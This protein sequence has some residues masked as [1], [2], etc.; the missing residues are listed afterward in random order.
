MGGCIM[1]R[2][3]P[4]AS[5]GETHGQSG[6]RWLDSVAPLREEG[7]VPWPVPITWSP[8]PGWTDGRPSHPSVHTEPWARL[9]RRAPLAPECPH[10]LLSA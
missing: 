10:S 8:E 2:G 7:R 9:D 6:N 1:S 5:G 3:S 4:P